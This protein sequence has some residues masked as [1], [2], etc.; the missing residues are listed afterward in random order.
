M[1][2]LQIFE[3]EEFGEIRTVTIN[4]EPW[5]VGKDVAKALGFTNSR[6]AIATHV[7]EEDKGVE[8]IDTPGGKQN[9]TVVNESGLYALV[10]GSRLD[11]AK[12]FK[13]W[14]TSE[15]LPSLRKT[16]S[17]EMK[18]YSPE[19]KAILMHDEKIVK[20]DGRVTDLEN[21]MVIDYGQQQTLKNEVN[22]VVVNALGGKESNAYKEVSKKVFS[23]INHE[24]Q[25]RFAVNSRNNIP[26]KRFDEAIA[27]V[28]S[29]Q[30]SKGTKWM[31]DGCNAQM[32]L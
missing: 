26:K 7:F 9:M 5:F 8:P 16:S 23:E 17:Y 24:I 15:V 22:K 32:S 29:W 18:N 28:R 6:D 4:N 20:I 14:V 1:N 25:E 27:F 11:S 3:N 21:N 19:M 30:P 31:I 13:H 2:E 10:F 12:K